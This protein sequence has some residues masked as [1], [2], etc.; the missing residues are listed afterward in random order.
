MVQQCASFA[1]DTRRT[2][3]NNL[4]IS[5]SELQNA[6]AEVTQS[7]MMQREH[8]D[9]ADHLLDV[10]MASRLSGIDSQEHQETRCPQ[11]VYQRIAVER[12]HQDGFKALTLPLVKFA[13]S[14]CVFTGATTAAA[15][16]LSSVFAT[17]ARSTFTS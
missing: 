8:K 11:L 13:A 10:I 14:K 2:S 1:S 6:E 15:G 7:L 16:Q 4:F 17:A 5:D 9:T 12:M 3:H